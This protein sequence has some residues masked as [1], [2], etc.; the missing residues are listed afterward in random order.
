MF[1]LDTSGNDVHEHILSTAWDV[2]TASHES[3][4]DFTTYETSAQGITF[5]TDGTAMCISGIDS[6]EI[7]TFSL[8]VGYDLSS[9][10]THEHSQSISTHI[11]DPNGL[12]FNNDGTRLYVVDADPEDVTMYDLDAEMSAHVV[13]D[14]TENSHTATSTTPVIGRG[15]IGQG[16]ALDGT[17]DYID[18]GNVASGIQTIAF[19]MKADDITTRD[20][21]DIDGTDR[22]EINGSSTIV[23]TSFPTYTIY[24]DGSS[25]SATID[26]DWHHVAITVSAGVNASDFEI[27]RADGGF[28]DGNI[29]DVR[30]YTSVLTQDE[31]TQLY[32]L[33]R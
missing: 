9:T 31:I 11:V 18:V 33:G 29:D 3:N 24:V 8:S 23:A 7:Q 14:G 26:S 27:G 1:V 25:S 4:Y 5:N 16:I 20:I 6:D 12:V 15:K 32:G 13:L 21:I 10:I 2:S 17:A 19:W 30:L 28:F 22:I